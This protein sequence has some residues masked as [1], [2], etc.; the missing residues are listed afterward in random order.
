[1]GRTFE[2]HSIA[3]RILDAATRLLGDD[4]RPGA[5]EQAARRECE[6]HTLGLRDYERE[7]VMYVLA[8]RSRGLVR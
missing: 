4:P 1:M 6:R 2:P 5:F 3:S 8:I 7:E